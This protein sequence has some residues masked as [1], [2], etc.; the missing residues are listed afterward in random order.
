MEEN[1][2]ILK[3]KIIIAGIS[4]YYRWMDYKS[5]SEIEDENGD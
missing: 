5:L 1:E 3:K 4:C 2:K